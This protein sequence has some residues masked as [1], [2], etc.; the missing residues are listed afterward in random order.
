MSSK[1]ASPKKVA[2]VAV[3]EVPKLEP[4]VEAEAVAEVSVEAEAVASE[5][6]ASEPE[7][8]M[9]ATK[10]KKPRKA[11]VVVPRVRSSKKQAAIRENI[12]VS[13]WHAALKQSGFTRAGAFVKVPKRGTP[14]HVSIK[15][16]QEKLVLEWQALGSIPDEYKLK[17]P[18]EPVPVE[19]LDAASSDANAPAVVEEPIKKKRVRKPKEL[20]AAEESKAAEGESEAS[21]LEPKPKRQRTKK[22]KEPKAAVEAKT[23]AVDEAKPAPKKRAPRKPKAV[24]E[25]SEDKPVE[26]EATE[27]KEAS[28]PAPKKRAPRKP[29]EP[30]AK[31]EAEPMDVVTQA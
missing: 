10:E 8:E 30:K 20:K 21:D 6:E 12:R 28:K 5:A 16:L 26:A 9:K 31:A 24:A 15:A 18:E 11:R 23:E 25:K 19:A 3:A 7:A 29:K 1:I 4:V 14:E 17:Q 22:P 2:A 27:P 13:A